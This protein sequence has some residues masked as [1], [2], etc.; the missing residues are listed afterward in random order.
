VVVRICN[1]STLEAEAEGLQDQSQL[2]LYGETL[3]SKRKKIFPLC[4]PHKFQFVVGEG[5]GGILVS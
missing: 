5:K 1:P 2:G 3:I 4:L